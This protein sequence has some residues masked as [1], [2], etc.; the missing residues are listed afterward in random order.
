LGLFDKIFATDPL[1]AL[2]KQAEEAPSAEVVAAL[3]NKYIELG[4]MEEAL[5]V[6]ERG[7]HTYKGAS[8]L[9]DILQFVKKKRSQEG[10]KRL[11]DEIRVKPTPAAYT[12][13]ADIYRD[14]GDVEQALELASEC[15][16]KFPTDPMAPLKIGQ[17]R[18]D[19]FLRDVIAY[20][21]IH[22][23]QAL[24]KVRSLDAGNAA[25]R[26]LLAQF[27][28]AVGANALSVQEL[29]AELDASPTAM[30][31]K[32]FLEEMGQ[33]PPLSNGVTIESLVERAEDMGAVPN[34]L[35]GFPRALRVVVERTSAGPKLNPSAAQN[36][37]QEL[38]A[39][40]GVRNIGIFDREGGA[41][42]SVSGEN[43]LDAEAFRGLV[44]EIARVS[45]DSCRHMDIGS[46]ARG[47]VQFPEGGAVFLRQRGTTFALLYR[48]PMKADKAAQMLSGVAV[49]MVGLP[50]GGARA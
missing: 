37:L 43:G 31:I 40:P 11:R 41:V 19:N 33:P 26:M 23:Y 6:V 47:G 27:Y 18:F 32:D 36:K 14:L 8:R 4:R 5:Q 39:T 25:C 44:A 50:P 29:K 10:V 12:E 24:Q 48:D 3:A 21:G 34:T 2:E 42:A 16:D 7:L 45:G 30:D 17:I 49:K 38:K 1:K 22:A 46:F 28:Y 9:Q 15:A 13:L 35:K 20:D